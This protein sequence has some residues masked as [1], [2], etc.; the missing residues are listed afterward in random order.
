ML[1]WQKAW[2]RLTNLHYKERDKCHGGEINTYYLL[3]CV[4]GCKKRDKNYRSEKKYAECVHTYRQP[5]DASL[6]DCQGMVTVILSPETKHQKQWVRLL[7]NMFV[8]L[9]GTQYIKHW[10]R[11]VYMKNVVPGRRD[12]SPNRV[13]RDEK[14]F[15]TFLCK[16][17][18]TVY[19]TSRD[20]GLSRGARD[21]SLSQ[22]EISLKPEITLSV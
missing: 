8:S 3:T 2:I 12:I 13:T 16:T 6:K 20:E 7:C 22:G 14:T 15:H 21:N 18:L 4:C 5:P 1:R 19:M 17:Q 10:S 9:M 11:P